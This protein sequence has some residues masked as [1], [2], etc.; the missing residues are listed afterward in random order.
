MV[1]QGHLR[2]P[3]GLIVRDY[4]LELDE[5][6]TAEGMRLATPARAAF[7]LGRIL[8]PNRAVPV[9]DALCNATHLKPQDVHQVADRHKGARG[10]VRLRSV[11]D[12]VDGGAES[13][14]E[15]R[16]RLLIT[17]AGLPRPQTQVVVLD[18]RGNFVARADMGWPEWKVLVE[19]EGEQH[20]TDRRQRARDLERYAV[21]EA[22]GWRVVRVGAEL[23]N[24][25]PHV[26]VR[27]VLDKLR[28][29]GAP[30]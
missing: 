27:R 18:E 16:T 5:I 3:K 11:L 12:D 26:L 9:L 25:R 23:L 21:L 30:V 24:D 10:I 28:A 29:A 8:P 1:R 22:L 17:R 7:D 13:P 19:Y 15:S 4:A 2:A 20:W 6:A 14:P